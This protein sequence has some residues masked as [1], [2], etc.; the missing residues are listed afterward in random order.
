MEEEESQE[1]GRRESQEK[2][3]EKEKTKKENS[4]KGLFTKARSLT[5]LKNKAKHK[6]QTQD[7]TDTKESL[8]KSEKEDGEKGEKVCVRKSSSEN[9]GDSKERGEQ[10]RHKSQSFDVLPLYEEE[11]KKKGKKKSKESKDTKDGKDGKKKKAK[12]RERKGKEKEK[13]KDRGKKAKEKEKEKEKGSKKVRTKEDEERQIA[14]KIPSLSRLKKSK[15]SPRDTSAPEEESLSLEAEKPVILP[16]KQPAR[17]KIHSTKSAI[18][19]Q[20]SIFV[21]DSSR[22]V[23]NVARP[24]DRPLSL[25]MIID[26]ETVRIPLLLSHLRRQGKLTEEAALKLLDISL[27]ILKKEP[28]VVMLEAPCCVFGDLHGQFY[29]LINLLELSGT[30]PTTQCLFLGDYV[31]RGMFGIETTFYLL[32]FKVN[33]PKMFWMLRGNH[34]S[35]QITD[36]FNF[37]RECQVK[38]S[39]AVYD[40]CM[41]VFDALPLAAVVHADF[42]DFF[43]VHGGI[44]PDVPKL[45]DIKK[46]DRFQETS[47][48]GPVASL[49]WSDPINPEEYPDM[50]LED[51][52]TFFFRPNEGRGCVG[53]LFGH[54]ATNSFLAK[55]KFI[56][57][58][59]GHEVQQFGI[60]EHYFGVGNSDFPKCITLFSAPNYCEIYDNKAAYLKLLRDSMDYEVVEA[61]HHPYV[62]PDFMNGLSFSLSFVVEIVAALLLRTAHKLFLDDE[63]EVE[64]SEDQEAKLDTMFKQAKASVEGMKKQRE[65]RMELLN[66]DISKIFK[67]AAGPSA[68]VEELSPFEMA[69]KID[70]NVES[71]KSLKNSLRRIKSNPF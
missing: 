4:K 22:V 27:N 8:Q 32:S 31:D 40:K 19:V 28:N 53:W 34:E 23:Q 55:N 5:N 7:K 47:F 11:P 12:G 45:R 56:T 33:F 21:A 39:E 9:L 44:G 25:D 46:I 65:G 70:R 43:C 37:H 38:Y 51:L 36:N 52:E 71:G 2:G 49:L 10:L 62:L 16:P 15:V 35:R 3:R 13:E 54:R 58:I 18:V 50:S 42:G 26:G 60:A 24:I 68:G 57:L 67:E 29:D 61:V 14:K 59:R 48:K 17:T 30:P 1:K 6:S 41:E 63:D 66:R 69:L 64:L 20:P